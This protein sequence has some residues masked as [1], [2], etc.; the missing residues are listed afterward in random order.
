MRNETKEPRKS[1][2]IVK[3]LELWASYYKTHKLY[4]DG[5]DPQMV[6]DMART[7]LA[8]VEDRYGCS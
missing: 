7:T 1:D 8:E 3:A 6:F 2:N 4:D 5:I